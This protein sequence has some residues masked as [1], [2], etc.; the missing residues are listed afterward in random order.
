MAQAGSCGCT[1]WIRRGIRSSS[2]AH[3][4]IAFAWKMRYLGYMRTMY[5][6]QRL[7][8]WFDSYDI[9]DEAGMPLFIVKG[10]LA[11]GH[12]LHIFEA[13]TNREVGVVKEKVMRLL[14]TFE[15]YAYGQY[16]GEIKKE[17]T[18][19][20]PRYSIDYNGWDIQG[21]ILGWEYQV[22]QGGVQIS[23]VSKQLFKMTDTFL[24]AVYQEADMLAALMVV[25]AI[26][27][28]NCGD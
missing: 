6:K 4:C 3:V 14:P 16:L 28:A 17:L 22:M 13:A 2:R 11:W 9:Y 5:F 21:D 23:S 1:M 15:L 8:S 10:K 12:Q 27:A 25:L 19:F 24:I 20:K 7:F 18:F 26:D